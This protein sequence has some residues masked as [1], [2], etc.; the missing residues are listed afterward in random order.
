MFELIKSGSSKYGVWVYGT[1]KVKGF[2]VTDIF[3][4]NLKEELTENA[5]AKKVIVKRNR[6]GELRF[7]IEF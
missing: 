2:E 3:N 1:L 6:K 7:T 4:T 5:T